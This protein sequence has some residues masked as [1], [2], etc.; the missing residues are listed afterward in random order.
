MNRKLVD[1]PITGIGTKERVVVL[2]PGGEKDGEVSSCGTVCFIHITGLGDIEIDTGVFKYLLA[3]AESRSRNLN[4]KEENH[5][6]S[7]S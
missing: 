7:P 2:Y 5:E 3:L 6:I 4:R 1:L